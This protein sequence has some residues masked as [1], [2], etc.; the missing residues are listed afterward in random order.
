MMKPAFGQVFLF[1]GY[2]SIPACLKMVD[3]DDRKVLVF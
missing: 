1:L 2:T 3:G